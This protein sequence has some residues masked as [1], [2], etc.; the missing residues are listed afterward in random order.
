MAGRRLPWAAL[1]VSFLL[2]GLQHAVVWAFMVY[3]ERTN[4]TSGPK[5]EY[6]LLYKLLGAPA[7][8]LFFLTI[9]LDV[10]AGFLLLVSPARAHWVVIPAAVLNLPL[11]R[12]GPIVGLSALMLIFYSGKYRAC[13]GGPVHENCEPGGQAQA[14]MEPQRRGC[15]LRNI[16]GS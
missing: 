13:Q 15:Y 5:T 4:A 3:I 14:D 2:L 7:L 10:A 12:L 1:G 8:W 9:L 6:L 16:R 11:I